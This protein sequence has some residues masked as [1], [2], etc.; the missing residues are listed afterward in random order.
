M[1]RRINFD[2]LSVIRGL[3]AFYVVVN[4]ARG[5]LFAGGAYL[6]SAQDLDLFD[7]LNLALLQLTSL[8]HEAVI[9]FFVLSGFSIAHSLNSN[10]STV[11]FL[12]NRFVRIYPPYV[13][14]FFVV[15]VTANLLSYSTWSQ[16][17][18]SYLNVFKYL[19]YAKSNG[20]FTAQYWSLVYEVIFYTL[21]PIVLLSKFSVYLTFLISVL[22]FGSSYYLNGG[23]FISHE[24]VFISFNFDVLIYFMVGV[25]TYN[26]FSRLSLLKFKNKF[27]FLAVFCLFFLFTLI[28]KKILHL[29]SKVVS[30]S[31]ALFSIF[32]IANV[33]G[34]NVKNSLLKFLGD[35]SY[36][37]YLNHFIVIS[38][39][40]VILLHHFNIERSDIHNYYAWVLIIPLCLF[41]S[42]FMWFIVER[43]CTRYLSNRRL[44]LKSDN[45][46]N[47]YSVIG[48]K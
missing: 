33:N 42:I 20:Y 36:S 5:N 32:I 28:S 38:V 15:V 3:A 29:D 34:W 17:Y 23:D 22:F 47:Q 40:Q 26:N 31:V 41:F 11:G 21:A 2:D 12:I 46:L 48:N 37:L 18:L 7:K 25:L 16:G 39:A 24:N 30:L 10:N 13:F 9:L 1:N 35:I 6:S 43:N 27:I 8:G 19:V 14:S 44:R 45:V 4:H